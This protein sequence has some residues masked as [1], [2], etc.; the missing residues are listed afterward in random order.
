[1]SQVPPPVPAASQPCQTPP[2]L[3]LQ[4][5]RRA[6]DPFGMLSSQFQA[7]VAWWTHPQQLLHEGF[8]AWNEAIRLYD[9][10]LRRLLGDDSADLVVPKR[11]DERFAD[12]AWLESPAFDI[13]KEGFLAFDHRLRTLYNSATL[14]ALESPVWPDRG[15]RQVLS[16]RF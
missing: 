4:T 7:Q 15:L 2:E 16:A 8:E 1:M 3:A 13:L 10:G 6:S 14:W 11:E 9:H 5:W 12:P